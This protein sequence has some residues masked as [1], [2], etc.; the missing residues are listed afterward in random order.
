MTL[1]HPGDAAIL[2]FHQK[3]SEKPIITIV[4]DGGQYQKEAVDIVECLKTMSIDTIDYMICTHFD[5]DHIGGFEYLLQ[6]KNY[7]EA[8]LFK[9]CVYISPGKPIYDN[10]R[11]PNAVH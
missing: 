2:T 9:D 10:D 4:I 3:S 11:I 8:K 5:S 1:Q 6:D 7:K